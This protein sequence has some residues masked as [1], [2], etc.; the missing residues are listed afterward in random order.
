MSPKAALFAAADNSGTQ[1]SPARPLLAGFLITVAALVAHWTLGE[2]LVGLQ[3]AVI[4]A[5]LLATAWAVIRQLRRGHETAT[6]RMYSSFTLVAAAFITFLANLALSSSWDSIGLLLK[7]GVAAALVGALLAAL[8]LAWRFGVVSLLVVLHFAGIFTCVLAVP[9]PNS[10]PPWLI[11]QIWTCF[12]RPY[13][14]FTYLNNGYHF[15]SPDPGGS[16]LIWFRVEYA[17]GSARW[18]TIPDQDYCGTALEV[19]RL[20]SVATSTTQMMPVPPIVPA[21]I[22]LKRQ[23]V[24]ST[25]NPPIPVAPEMDINFQYREPAPV[26]KRLLES[27]ARYVARNYQ[28]IDDPSQPVTGVKIYRVDYMFPAP[29]FFAEGMSPYDP[30][31]YLAYYQGDFAPDGKLKP[32]CYTLELDALGQVTKQEQDAFLYWLIP[33]IRERDPSLAPTTNNP[34]ARESFYTVR[35]LNVKDYVPIHAGDVKE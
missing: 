29:E 34:Y 24:G 11:N 20:G 18:I 32:E 14:Q 19:R 8:P 35:L 10:Q 21:P 23:L 26:T 30:T 27:Y 1:S 12:Y 33:T 4:T 31:L 9:P 6:D 22:V 25:R 13:L 28:S 2:S 15:Y 7:V 17:D 5:G 16:T 3:G